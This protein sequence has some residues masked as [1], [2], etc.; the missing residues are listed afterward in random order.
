MRC[1]AESTALLLPPLWVFN[2]NLP[3]TLPSDFGKMLCDFDPRPPATPDVFATMTR[4]REKV[5]GALETGDCDGGLAA[6][7]TYLPYAFGLLAAAAEEKEVQGCLTF[8][9]TA[10]FT[11]AHS[12]KPA[13]ITSLQSE[14]VLTLQAYALLHRKLARDLLASDAAE[15][16]NLN[17]SLKHLTKA[18]GIFESI[19]FLS[20]SLLVKNAAAGGASP[21]L[22]EL[23][24]EFQQLMSKRV[25][26][27]FRRSRFR[28]VKRRRLSLLE[29]QEIAVRKALVAKHN[30][31]V[32][33]KLCMDVFDSARHCKQLVPS[34]AAE[35]RFRVLEM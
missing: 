31:V 4:H 3:R 10:P 33:A 7:E 17:L 23:T 16:A 32:C 25:S 34:A 20:A 28:D 1:A 29:A 14:V 35:Y 5:R 12:S 15:E 27:R 19:G 22:H 30:P 11:N 18:A 13:K 8:A 24:P 6:V 21:L 9:W 26:L 2:A